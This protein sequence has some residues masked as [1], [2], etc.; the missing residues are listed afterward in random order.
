MQLDPDL[1]LSLLVFVIVLAGVSLAARWVFWRAAGSRPKS[2]PRRIGILGAVSVTAIGFA[3]AAVGA[4]GENLVGDTCVIGILHT[5]AGICWF[6]MFHMPRVWLAGPWGTLVG[7]A[8]LLSIPIV[9]FLVFAGG[10]ALVACLRRA[11]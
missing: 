8:G 5:L 1:W 7:F 11:R 9:W 6:P 2:A 4:T 3:A 10:A